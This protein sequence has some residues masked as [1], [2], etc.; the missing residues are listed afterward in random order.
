MERLVFVNQVATCKKYFWLLSVLCGGLLDLIVTILPECYWAE[1]AVHCYSGCCSDSSKVS[2][3]W[4]DRLILTFYI[5]L[6]GLPVESIGSL[7][8]QFS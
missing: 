5:D 2:S 7:M 4:L 6:C 3:Y 8:E 1:C